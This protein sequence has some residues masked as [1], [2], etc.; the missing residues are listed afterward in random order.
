MV[1]L[2]SGGLIQERSNV[3]GDNNKQYQEFQLPFGR[4]KEADSVVAMRGVLEL[5][6]L[7]HGRSPVRGGV[8][9]SEISSTIG[10]C[11]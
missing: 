1:A 9:A 11:L 5:T 2:A 3:R 8:A 7:H 4:L 10:N 6:P